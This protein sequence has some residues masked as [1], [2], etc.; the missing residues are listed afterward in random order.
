[1]TAAVAAR[2]FGVMRKA[3][4]GKKHTNRTRRNTGLPRGQDLEDVYSLEWRFW[5]L[6]SRNGALWVDTGRPFERYEV[7]KHYHPLGGRDTKKGLQSLYLR[8]ARLANADEEAIVGFAQR[9]GLPVEP[10]D[11]LRHAYPLPVLRNNIRL[12][13]G[14]IDLWS[15]LTATEPATGQLD[16][17]LESIRSDAP[18]EP[19]AVLRAALLRYVEVIFESR[20]TPPPEWLGLWTHRP[21]HYSFLESAVSHYIPQ[22]VDGVSRQ[23]P[24][25]ITTGP[26]PQ[27]PD[28]ILDQH[29]NLDQWGLLLFADSYFTDALRWARRGEQWCTF[30][31]RVQIRP[32]P[33]TLLDA[34][35]TMLWLDASKDSRVRRCQWRRCNLP[36]IPTSAN[37]IYCSPSCASA[38]SALASKVRSE[39]CQGKRTSNPIKSPVAPRKR[40]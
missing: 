14:V 29:R 13:A 28:A 37:N 20:Q 21:K 34:L 9:W 32:H 35:Y 33:T 19:F 5:P 4:L 6:N 7:F 36:F 10:A 40:R 12:L 2:Y 8:F 26:S 25:D 11:P 31:G 23:V 18:L 30:R 15:A 27:T 3:L 17:P 38:A 22:Q 24:H 16:N 39:S 1:L